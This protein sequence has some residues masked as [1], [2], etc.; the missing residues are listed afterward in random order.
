[1]DNPQ[2]CGL[3][4]RGRPERMLVCD[5]CAIRRA[6]AASLCT[7]TTVVLALEDAIYLLLNREMQVGVCCLL[8]W[9]A[10]SSLQSRCRNN[11]GKWGDKLFVNVFIGRTPVCNAVGE[12]WGH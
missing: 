1:V 6:P 3:D 9:R 2:R 7:T 4:W 11:G 8:F 12:C 10:Y 5:G